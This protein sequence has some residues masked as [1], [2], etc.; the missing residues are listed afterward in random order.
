MPF[1]HH[2]SCKSFHVVVIAFLGLFAVLSPKVLADTNLVFEGGWV[3]DGTDDTGTN[4]SDITMSVNGHAVGA[5]SELLVSY[6]VGDTGVVAVATVKGSGEIRLALPPPGVFGGSFY[7]TGYWDCDA[8]FVPGLSITKLDVRERGGRV[9]E[10]MFRGTVS[11]LVSMTAK[12]FII[13][14]YPPQLDSFRADV[15][16][17]LFATT[18]FCVDQVTHTNQ[19]DF[20]V[21]R[22][23][24]NYISTNVNEND[25]TRYFKQT[26]HDCY[27]YFC[28]TKRKSFCNTLTNQDGF[29]IDDPP[30]LGEGLVDLV[31]SQDLPAETPTLSVRFITP[32]AGQIEPQGYVTSSAD[33]TAQNVSFWGNWVR[34]RS[35][36]RKRQVVGRFSYT[37]EVDSPQA[38]A[39]DNTD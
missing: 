27:V 22:M 30:R 28:I 19:D 23:A 2:R 3:V 33:P 14:M 12:N 7:T 9:K 39:C 29:V 13:T 26:E 18:N 20:E 8:G 21:A 37:L 16:Y 24:S 10:L 17:T 31:H 32:P 11:N 35:Q 4:A 36:Y 15:S 5:F 1:V 38:I 34:A 6:D 25:E